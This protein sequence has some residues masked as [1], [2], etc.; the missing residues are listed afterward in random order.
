MD[1][2][3]RIALFAL[4][5]FFACAC[6]MTSSP[7]AP[8]VGA[9]FP[10][11]QGSAGTCDAGAGKTCGTYPTSLQLANGPIAGGI[12]KRL[13]WTS[14][15]GGGQ[16]SF[17]DAS[18]GG[19]SLPSGTPGQVIVYNDASTGTATTLS[20][21][22]VVSSRGLVTCSGLQNQEVVAGASTGTLTCATGATA[23]G[24]AQASTTGATGVSTKFSTQASTNPNGTP[25]GF[26]VNIPAHT[27]S[28][29]DAQMVVEL[30]GTPGVAIGS[31][32][33]S[34][35]SYQSIYFGNGAAAPGNSNYAFLADVA[36]TFTRLN[37]PTSGGTIQFYSANST[38]WMS[39]DGTQGA[40]LTNA[41]V[42]LQVGSLTADVGSGGGVVGL[43]KAYANP[44]GSST[45][46][47]IY[48]DH[49]S[50]NFEIKPPGSTSSAFESAT[51]NNTSKVPLSVG[52]GAAA[53]ACA[54]GTVTLSA[55]NSNGFTK[56]TCG[57]GVTTT[58]VQSANP[59]TAGII[60]FVRN[61]SSVLLTPQ[62]SS[63]SACTGMAGISS[64]VLT[65]DGT[66]CITLMMGS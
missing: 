24:M 60:W 57:S 30:A 23:C 32:G 21:D 18:S 25:G 52:Y 31:Y 39:I 9:S 27:G 50:G 11:P 15:G 65:G 8:P 17:V 4:L 61:A 64:A 2:H 12:N 1:Q 48:A 53:I 38:E 47:V 42:N 26:V 63:G 22:C 34:G 56:L 5:S 6:G 37:V 45:G 62:F 40:V 51:A 28:G 54:G 44:S 14:D 10:V 41:N 55:A 59:P 29:S 58:T 46:S 33:A 36:N 13:A 7:D 3:M 43:S 49:T 35:S 16:Y 19:G 66:N 20:E